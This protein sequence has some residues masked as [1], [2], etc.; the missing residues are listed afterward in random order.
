MALLKKI[1]TVTVC[2][3]LM[4]MFCAGVS[5]DAGYARAEGTISASDKNGHKESETEL[6]NLFTDAVKSST[7]ADMAFL[8]CGDLSGRNIIAGSV[9]EEAVSV[10]LSSD[11]EIV[12]FQA[13]AEY[14][15]SSLHN[16]VSHFVLNEAEKIEWEA[17]AFDGYLY[18]SGLNVTF[19]Y[20]AL[21]DDPVYELKNDGK[22][23][24]E[25]GDGKTYWIAA[26]KSVAEG[27]YGYTPVN[28]F[29]T[30]GTISSCVLSYLSGKE[31][32]SAPATGRV[33]IIGTKEYTLAARFPVLLIVVVAAV[34][35]GGGYLRQRLMRKNR[36]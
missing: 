24:I 17:S 20:S 1:I 22:E 5:A 18:L 15:Y 16:S 19:D 35:G 30:M 29:E 25:R 10:C 28:D 33:K 14:I 26:A 7:G 32:V 6:G 13:D 12:L 2:L 23:D 34:F 27:K 9:D 4:C 31:S 11:E 36:R 21:P 3:C 8:P